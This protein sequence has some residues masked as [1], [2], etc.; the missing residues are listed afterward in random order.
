MEI[1]Q[2]RIS[3]ESVSDDFKNHF[4][5][6]YN[7]RIIF[8][9][10][11]GIGKTTF[12]SDFFKKGNYNTVWISPIKY[13]V[14]SNEDVFEYIKFDIIL[15]LFTKYL[16]VEKKSKIPGSLFVWSYLNNNPSKILESFFNSI[17]LLQPKTKLA[18]E[19]VKT[20]KKNYLDYKKY[21]E[22]LLEKDK[23]EVDIFH[24]YLI[25]STQKVGSI[26]EDDFITQ[27]IR[28]YLETLKEGEKENVLIIDDF[29]RLDP[30]HIF[31]ILNILSVH[32]DYL[33]NTYKNKFGF[34]KI[35][36]VCDIDSIENFYQHKYG[37]KAN[38]TG[39]ID[40]FCSTKYFRFSNFE[41]V[42]HFCQE[43][44]QLNQLPKHCENSLLF[45][46]LHLLKEEKITLR[47]LL[48]YR[49]DIEQTTFIISENLLINKRVYCNTCCFIDTENFCI[50]TTNFPFI[51]IIAILA[52]IFGDFDKLKKCFEELSMKEYTED[53]PDEFIE[54]MVN[55]LALFSHLAKHDKNVDKLC[56]NMDD[57][58]HGRYGGYG[59]GG[60]HIKFP[61][62]QFC[63][64]NMTI[65]LQWS[66]ANKYQGETSYFDGYKISYQPKSEGLKNYKN[67]YSELNVIIDYLDLKNF[68]NRI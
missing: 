57:S 4:S 52:N 44:I 50:D 41:A 68:K 61:A 26:F 63:K 45:I 19:M 62:T 58:T 2:Q 14:G 31:R 64:S 10:K 46:I 22:E 65:N 66:K 15:E 29:D 23:S 21:K 27:A 51:H 42:K 11:F 47:N 40:K 12:L 7:N 25:S 16:Q 35:I 34:D 48:K 20:F 28:T 36:I 3:I 54:D 5:P 60:K 8:S 33:S 6:T 55:S 17:T 56:F 37:E 67:L 9:G 49:Y 43:N 18:L 1:E 38:F 59:Y 39:Y 53:L 24:E 30:E 32:N 13:S